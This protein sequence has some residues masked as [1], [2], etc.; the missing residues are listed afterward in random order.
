[1]LYT[2]KMVEDNIRNREKKRVFYLG[3]GDTLTSEARD[4]LQ[5]QRIQIL[6]AAQAKKERWQILGGGFVE[7]KPEHMT[8]LNGDVLVAKTHP[9]IAFRGWVD[10]LEAELLLVGKD[11]P[12]LQRELEEIL[13]LARQIIRCDVLEEPLHL[14]GLCGLTEAE[15]RRQSHFPQEHFGIAHFM[16][17]FTDNKPI[18]ALNRLRAVARQTELAAQHAFTDREGVP[19]REDIMQA[20]NRISSMLY[21]LMLR[22][23]AAYGIGEDHRESH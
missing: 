21:I 16:P 3:A 19:V 5:S 7:E 13:I 18:L 15:M 2:R 20:L 12:R 1:M 17:G 11:L 22:E 6:P 9:R 8:H 14:T 4:F 10:T 23:K